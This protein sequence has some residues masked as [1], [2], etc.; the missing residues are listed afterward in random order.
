M[1]TFIVRCTKILNGAMIIKAENS[2]DA[3]KEAQDMLNGN[4]DCIDWDFGEATA[5]YADEEVILDGDV[6]TDY[7]P[8]Y[9]VGDYIVSGGKRVVLF[10]IIDIRDGKYICSDGKEDDIDF[11]DKDPDYH[12]A[13][14][15]EVNKYY[16]TH[17]K[18]NLG[19][20]VESEDYPA[21]KVIAISGENY[22]FESGA[23]TPI[24]YLD[25]EC[26]F[27]KAPTIQPK[28]KVGEYVG[29]F[30]Y[31]YY[32]ITEIKDG[33]YIFEDGDAVPIKN[34]D[35]DENHHVEFFLRE[36]LKPF[37]KVLVRDDRRCI[38]VADFFSHIAGVEYGNAVYVTCGGE[39]WEQCVP[40]NDETA[41]LIGGKQDYHGKYQTW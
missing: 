1:K 39:H 6:D 34:F 25:N 24:D 4:V 18:Y 30:H 13:T 38:W 27:H 21:D 20:Y 3:V 11:L 10:K 23:I 33:E 32:K 36:D 41:Y 2:E 17:H 7:K 37:D 19:D 40:Y 5:D 14:N 8:K 26:E 29:D 12:L 35:A 9:N 16:Q 28:Y 15:D 31:G 22:V